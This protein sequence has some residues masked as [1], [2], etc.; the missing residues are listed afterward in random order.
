M[1]NSKRFFIYLFSLTASLLFSSVDTLP[2]TFT[3]VSSVSADTIPGGDVSGTWYQA[4]SPYYITGDITVQSSDTL[5]IEPGVEVYFMIFT[6]T[7]NGLL[8][9]I[10]T[11][12]DSIYLDHDT[13]V[14][15]WYGLRFDNAQDCSH[16]DYCSFGN[17]AWI[18]SQI[19]CMYNSDPVISHC[20]IAGDQW[21]PNIRVYDSSNPSISD[22]LITGGRMGIWWSSTANCTINGCTLSNFNGGNGIWKDKGNLTMTDCTI[23]DVWTDDYCGAGIRSDEGDITLINCTISNCLSYGAGGGIYCYNGSHTLTN[24]TFNG[25]TSY[26]NF[27]P[28]IGGAGVCFDGG[29]ASLSYCTFYDNFSDPGGGAITINGTGSLTIDHCTID[30]NTAWNGSSNAIWL[31][32]NPITNINNTIVSNN[33]GTDGSIYNQGTLTVEYSDFYNN[34]GSPIVGNVPAG[35]GVL[36]RVNYNADSCDCYYNIFMDPMYV[37]TLN[38][39]FHLTAGSPCID[40]GD[41]AFPYDPD[42]TITDM[43]VYYFSQTPVEEHSSVA[44]A[45]GILKISPIPCAGLLTISFNVTC[46]TRA[47]IRIYDLQGRLLEEIPIVTGIG[48][49]QYDTSDLAAGIY[50]CRLKSGDRSETRTFVVRR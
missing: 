4:N 49:M 2:G 16:L 3:L 1:N 20:R 40:A 8:E 15:G 19:Y 12:S 14:T 23:S 26:C 29:N 38:N 41:P 31:K 25:D 36:D 9:A 30:R 5:I 44:V 43:G 45:D 32:G 35:F 10:G 13:S 42:G 34:D 21:G 46:D 11:E 7:V 39:D 18:F 37:D 6:F 22:C 27:A 28:I 47:E 48:E 17:T 24:C 33:Y 50:F